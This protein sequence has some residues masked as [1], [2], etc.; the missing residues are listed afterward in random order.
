MRAAALP[1]PLSPFSGEK[2]LLLASSGRSPAYLGDRR[3]SRRWEK[4]DCSTLSA[5][6]IQSWK[7][8]APVKQGLR[9]GL[10]QRGCRARGLVSS[11]WSHQPSFPPGIGP[12]LL[13]AWRAL[14]GESSDTTSLLISAAAWPFTMGLDPTGQARALQPGVP[15]PDLS[16]PQGPCSHFRDEKI[17]AETDQ[18]SDKSHSHQQVAGLE[19]EVGLPFPVLP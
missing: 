6:L 7:T 5:A 1:C 16:H 10:R 9:T 2:P 3:I 17:E 13:A 19:L 14:P 18:S 8:E 15:T 4:R 11:A 12:E